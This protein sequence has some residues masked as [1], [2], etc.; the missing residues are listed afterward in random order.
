MIQ[1]IANFL[2][3][4]HSNQQSRMFLRRRQALERD[5]L[6]ATT[7][8][9]RE[10]LARQLRQVYLD[11]KLQTEQNVQ[12]AKRDIPKQIWSIGASGKIG[13]EKQV[14]ASAQ[15]VI[16]KSKTE[17]NRIA[18]N[19]TNLDGIQ[20]FSTALFSNALSQQENLLNSI[21]ED[22]SKFNQLV[23]DRTD[24]TD[25]EVFGGSKLGILR[26]E[27][28]RFVSG[29]E[30]KYGSFFEGLGEDPKK[31]LYKR[32]SSGGFDAYGSVGSIKNEDFLAALKYGLDEKNKY[33]NTF[34]D[35]YLD[36]GFKWL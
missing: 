16:S 26:R 36:R 31:V 9:E 29:K 32:D 19:M 13:L 5:Y 33:H 24:E 11:L 1:G 10:S 22:Y 21:T 35:F 7:S 12:K 4:I 15:S 27:Y 25:S 14:Q 8:A 18:A 3:G 6:N 2:F 20:E 30:T 23:E 34:I 28:D 17:Q